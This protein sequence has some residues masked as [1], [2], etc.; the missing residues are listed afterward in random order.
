M[1]ILKVTKNKD[2]HSLQAVYFAKY[3]LRVK[4]WIFLNETSL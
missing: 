2:L 1:I 4:V 3:I